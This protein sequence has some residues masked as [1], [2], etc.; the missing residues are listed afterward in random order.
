MNVICFMNQS[1]IL[2]THPQTDTTD[3]H[4]TFLILWDVQDLNSPVNHFNWRTKKLPGGLQTQR[5]LVP[6]QVFFFLFLR[7][8]SSPP[9]CMMKRAVFSTLFCRHRTSSVEESLKPH[10]QSVSLLEGWAIAAQ[11]ILLS[12]LPDHS[13]WL[14]SVPAWRSWTCESS[15]Y[16]GLCEVSSR[17]LA[18]DAQGGGSCPFQPWLSWCLDEGL[19]FTKAEMVVMVFFSFLCCVELFFLLKVWQVDQV[20]LTLITL[21]QDKVCKKKL[22][23]SGFSDLQQVQQVWYVNHRDKTM[24]AKSSSTHPTRILW[25]AVS[26]T[27]VI[28]SLTQDNVCKQL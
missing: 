18:S 6:L 10:T 25:Y 7:Y 12:H 26:P 3:L 20:K 23:Y 22:W 24:C 8:T 21:S 9:V 14:V 13:C 27:T 28:S 11:R 15:V 19:L 16:C 5:L 4:H 1:K 2:N 17:Q